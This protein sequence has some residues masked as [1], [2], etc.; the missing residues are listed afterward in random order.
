[1]DNAAQLVQIASLYTIVAMTT[2]DYIQ[3][4]SGDMLVLQL[5]RTNSP[6]YSNSDPPPV[7]ATTST[8]TIDFWIGFGFAALI[9]VSLWIS[10]EFYIDFIDI[11]H[12]I[13]AF[14]H[15]GSPHLA[16]CYQNIAN[17]VPYA[18][19]PLGTHS[20]LLWTLQTMET[21]FPLMEE[22]EKL[23]ELMKEVLVTRDSSPL[24]P[25]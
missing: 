8:E 22:M 11:R 3:K 5:S 16:K 18:P 21:T 17:H 13:R 12:D 23:M 25:N 7:F 9:Y 6:P 15:S 14:M 10:R 2:R 20:K 19:K 4:T 1:M 24:L